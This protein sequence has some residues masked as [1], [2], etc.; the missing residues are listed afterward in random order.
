MTPA[1]PTIT[2]IIAEL[3]GLDSVGETEN[4]FELGGTSLELIRLMSAI[5]EQFH[6]ELPVEDLYR[7][8][9]TAARL[10]LAILVRT[11]AE[12]G[13]PA[14]LHALVESM[15]DEEVD[16]MLGALDADQAR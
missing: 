10:G 6:V 11:A 5:R 13:D 4:F 14:E 16:S 15:T 2:S 12:S 7:T 9:L 8:D 3:L 1:G